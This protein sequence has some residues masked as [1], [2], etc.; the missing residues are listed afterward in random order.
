MLDTAVLAYAVGGE[1][2]EQAACRALLEAATRG[3][4]EL[5]VSA[6]AVQEF[7]FHRLRRTSRTEAV[8][9]ARD[10]LAL[11]VVHPFDEAVARELLAV[12]EAS[13][14]GGRDAVHAATAVLAGFAA[15]VSPDRDFDSAP[16]LRR[17][18]PRDA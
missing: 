4:V 6:E 10:V 7:L 18:E 2:P 3:E 16:G 11:C 12:V 8:A 17:L 14:L 1:H 9:Q 5:H 13:S 15:I